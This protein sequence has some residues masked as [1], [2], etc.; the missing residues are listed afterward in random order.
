MMK[1]RYIKA[2]KLFCCLM[3]VAFIAPIQAN[4][5]K[6]YTTVPQCYEMMITISDGGS[7]ISADGTTHRNDYY[8]KAEE[9]KR[10]QL[11]IEA[12]D[13]YHIEKVLVNNMEVELVNN[14]L[15]IDKVTKDMKIAVVFTK[16]QEI[17][18]PTERKYTIV[19]VVMENQKPVSNV[20]LELHSD[21][22]TYTTNETGEFRF[23][24]VEEGNHTLYAYRENQLIG[25]LQ[26]EL[27]E[28]DGNKIIQKLADGTYFIQLHDGSTMLELHL[29]L[30][31]DGTIEITEKSG[32]IDTGDHSSAG[33]WIMMIIGAGTVILLKKKREFN[34]I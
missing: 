28:G 16:N 20:K 13:G 9:N 33:L 34:K 11:N 10:Y 14:K 25:K 8:E 26:F 29:H 12:D 18:E 23:H 24:D 15:I 1:N 27:S 22:K 32:I 4:E 3:M 21:V 2:M 6:I 5:T 17:V 7:V 30:N 31:E 19:G